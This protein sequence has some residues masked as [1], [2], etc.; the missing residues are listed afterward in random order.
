[1]AVTNRLQILVYGQELD[2]RSATDLGISFQRIADDEVDLSKRYGEFSYSFEL[3]ITK[4]NSTIFLSANAHGRKNIFV[5]N[6]DLPCQ[7]YNNNQLL[8]DGVISL[9]EVTQTS[10]VVIF[11]SKLKEFSDLIADKSLQDLEFPTITWEYEKTIIQH[12]RANYETS[13]ETYWQ[14][15]LTYY[16]TYF[17][18]YD[19]YKNKQD[20]RGIYFDIEAYTYQQYYYL[21]NNVNSNAENRFYHHQLPPA[22]YMVSLL[23][24]IFKDAGWSYSGQFFNNENIKRIVMLYAGDDDLYDR[25]VTA[26]A[27]DYDESGGIISTSGKTVQLKPAKLCCDM[28]QSDFLNGIMNMFNLYPVVDVGRKNIKFSP[29]TEIFGDTFNPYDITNKVMKET[30]KFSYLENNDPNITFQTPDNFRIMGDNT[31]T[32]GNTTNLS[33]QYWRTTQDS[34]MNTFYNRIGTT[35]DIELPFAAPTIKKTWLWNDEDISGTNHNASAH[36]IVHPLISENTPRNTQKFCGNTGQTYV[37]NNE[38]FLSFAGTPS[39][40]Y[41]YGKSSAD[42]IN[43]TG[44]GA[45]SNYYY[46]NIYT[47]TT[48]NRVPICFCSPFQLSTY[49]TEIN[50]YRASPDNMYSVNTIASTYLSTLWNLLG[51]TTPA[52]YTGTTTDFSLVFD[53]NGK[54]HETLWSKFHKPKYD[55]YRNS[56]VLSADM[57]MSEYDWDSMQLNRPISY[58]GEIFHILSLESYNPL[59]NTCSIRLIKTL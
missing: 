35:S 7:V 27:A 4:N 50:A 57:L 10:F 37:F 56:E 29:Y 49:R 54:F 32:T 23:D 9:Q 18:P 36:V 39:L 58:N 20:F 43:K 16:G 52:N 5:P 14:F 26:S 47:G 51:K 15:P 24:Q 34:E 6:R 11:Y 25:A 41:Y 8:L 1:M 33:S 31:A 48:Q 59:K 21:I 13:D 2:Y 46:I 55:R 28:S 22:F 45:A 12:I 19:T 38:G 44:A 17:T 42:I 53:S 40:H 30:V 3:P